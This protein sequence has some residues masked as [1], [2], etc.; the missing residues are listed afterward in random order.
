MLSFRE[1]SKDEI[2]FLVPCVRCIMV[3]SSL[4]IVGKLWQ[5][6]A[7]ESS[8]GVGSCLESIVMKSDGRKF[9]L[10]F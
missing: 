10:W 2:A 1:V 6:I 9:N 7:R 5:S 8:H 3:N 4:K